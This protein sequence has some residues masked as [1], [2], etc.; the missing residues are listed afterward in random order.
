VTQAEG[1]AAVTGAKLLITH[2]MAAAVA[3]AHAVYTDV[4]A[5]MGQEQEAVERKRAF[6]ITRSTAKLS[7]RRCPKRLHALSARQ[8]AMKK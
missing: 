4:W 3:G 8:S 7:R 1:L 6:R 5:S 2:D